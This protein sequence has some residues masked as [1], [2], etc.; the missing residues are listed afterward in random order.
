VARNPPPRRTTLRWCSRKAFRSV[1][2]GETAGPP[3]MCDD[4]EEEEGEVAGPA[5]VSTGSECFMVWFR[6]VYVM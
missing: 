5:V 4:T 2:L 1:S 6:Y 3:F